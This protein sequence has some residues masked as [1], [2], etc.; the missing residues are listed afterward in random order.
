MIFITGKKVASTKLRSTAVYIQL[1]KQR[2][3]NLWIGGTPGAGSD[4][5][6]GHDHANFFLKCI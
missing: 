6:L 3:A 2:E 1:R 5:N 4:T